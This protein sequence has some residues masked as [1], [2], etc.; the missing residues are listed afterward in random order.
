MI[1]KG[2]FRRIA[3]LPFFKSC[4]ARAGVHGVKGFRLVS[5]TKTQFCL[6]PLEGAALTLPRCSFEQVMFASQMSEELLHKKVR[7]IP[8]YG[9]VLFCNRARNWQAFLGIMILQ[10]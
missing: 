6:K 5:R 7:R 4:L 10:T 2:N 8:K 9:S 1:V 3:A